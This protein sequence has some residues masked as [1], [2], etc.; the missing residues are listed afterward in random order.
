LIG[1]ATSTKRERLEKVRIYLIVDAS[2]RVQPIESFL[3][4]AIAGGVG[5]VQLRE[6]TLPDA[7]LIEVAAR[8]AALCRERDVPFIVN[9][10]LDVALASAADGVHLGQ[11]DLPVAIARR[12]GGDDL[13]VGLSTHSPEQIDAAALT[14]ADYLG[15]GPV[16]ATPT[17]EGRTPVGLELVGYAAT[18][19]VQP[20][21]AIGGIDPDN[22][23]AVVRAGARGVSVLRWIARSDDPRLA[24]SALLK[25]MDL[26]ASASQANGD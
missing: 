6:K 26:T 17:K 20:F 11:D 7:E 24:A 3:R 5:M 14:E 9:D 12:V 2:P 23:G 1:Q 16:H 25:R 8:C 22:A 15:V 18:H 10:R 19:A 13:I 21:F 4:S